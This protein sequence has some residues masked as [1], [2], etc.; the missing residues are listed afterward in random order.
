LCLFAGFA[1]A[2]GA[3]V[4]NEHTPGNIE[5]ITKRPVPLKGI[6]IILP[7]CLGTALSMRKEL[8]DTEGLNKV[9]AG[10]LCLGLRCY[11]SV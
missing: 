11:C 9:G 3:V 4:V 10:R 2:K 6:A 1:R 7:K 5:S 8:T